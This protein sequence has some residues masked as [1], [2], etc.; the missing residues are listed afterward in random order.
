ME[1]SLRLETEDDHRTVE[2]ITREAFWNVY[3]PGCDE[4]LLIKN[5][6]K[7]KKFVPALDFVAECNGKI[8]GNIVYIESGVHNGGKK[9]TVLSFGPV[10]VLP[11]YQKCGVG[12][13]LVRHTIELARGMGYKAIIIY[14]DLEYYAR[15]GFRVSRE[16][17]ITD[18]ENKYPAAL[19]VLELSP[20]ALKGIEGMF[21]EDAIYPIDE[22]ELAEFEKSFPKKEKFATESQKRF[23]ELSGM[24]L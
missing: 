21:D 3:I 4:H 10:S 15:F 7:T 8:V 23:T 14:G 6:R 1:I 22:Q 11:E 2:E 18:K 24:Y 13:K 16:F 17:R 5:L 9:H 20:H 19:L 12:S